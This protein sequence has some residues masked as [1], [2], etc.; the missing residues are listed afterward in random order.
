MHNDALDYAIGTMGLP[1]GTLMKPHMFGKN[2]ST[3]V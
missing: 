1:A 3:G 2:I